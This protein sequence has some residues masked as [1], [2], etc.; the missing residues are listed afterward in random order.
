M[1]L[2]AVLLGL[3]GI[4]AAAESPD[5]TDAAFGALLA[6]PGAQPHEGGWIIPEQADPAPPN[7]E[8]LIARLRDLKKAGANFNAMRH[9][10]TLLAHAIR[11][12]KDRTAIWLLN[13]GADPKH[14]L[15]ANERSAYDLATE[16][17]RAA[18]KS[19]LEAK[20]G[21]KPSPPKAAGQAA[22]PAAAPKAA[23]TP[24]S[25]QQQTI[26]LM[27]RLL[28]PARRPTEAGRQE[29]QKFASTLS[30]E[31]YVATFRDG[32]RLQ[33]LVRLV[34]DT[35]GGLEGAL[36][37]LPVDLVRRQAQG[38]AELLAEVSYP[39]Y[40]SA[41]QPL[42]FTAASRNWP[43]LWKRIDQR[44]NYERYPDLAGR[45]PPAL[46]AGLFA[47]GYAKHDAEVTGCLLSAASADS[48]KAFW[49]DFLRHFSDAREQAT[50]LVLAN[51][52]FARERSPCYYA[53]GPAEVLK[54]LAFLR[55]QG[56]SR[57]VSG[58]R[59]SRLQESGDPSL[60]TALRA[61][62]APVPAAPRLRK[63]L[64]SC[65]LSLND[66]WLSA[67]IKAR[68]VGWG[69]PPVTVQAIGVPG[70]DRCG[71]ALSGD[72][73][74]ESSDTYDD[75]FNG[76][77][78]EGSTRCADLPDDGEIWI[79]KA[80]TISPVDSG[81]DTRGSGFIFRT[82]LDQKTGKRY[83]LDPG[84]RGALCSQSWELPNA[85]EWQAGP[86]GPALRPSGDDALVDGLLREQCREVAES[87]SLSCQGIGV[88]GEYE[89][90]AEPE[91]KDVLAMLREGEAVP[92]QRLVDVV[93]VERKKAY[94]AAIAARDRNEMRRLLSMGIAARWT[95]AEIR[96]LGPAELPLEE[97]RR[98]IALLFANADQ[99]DLAM[100]ED[101]FG[102]TESL[103][104]WLPMQDWGPVLRLIERS[105]DLWRGA[106]GALRDAAEKAGRGDLACGVDRAQG[107]LCGGGVRLD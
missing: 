34:R 8:A 53:S 35:D 18:V 97:K 42:T 95:A 11:A 63:A 92:I 81:S 31:D 80:G 57:P 38:I 88:L 101:R 29:W 89:S 79:E 10:G 20:F 4:A 45:V 48:L 77:G 78:R 69:I 7:E 12:G 51:Y 61:L 36:S 46:W 76:P 85:Y 73:Y 17:Q 50:S 28:G 66:A 82:V 49:P 94:Q 55:E 68:T 71:L 41:D 74:G 13:N 15:F 107:Y 6:M 90:G 59:M 75:F 104:G 16:S 24:K 56:V 19:V 40:S 54:K 39:L 86:R 37:P 9:R 25:R 60:A 103:L 96:A 5:S 44:L 83:L 2:A 27:D 32:E 1:L 43:A 62:S 64:L 106:A 30:R 14:V 22:T 3:A 47:S 65:T 67:L 98:R 91:A 99:L 105:P 21:F 87:Q 70:Q 100:S 93:G 102:L 84:K 33:E 26:E 23:E 58:L 72:G 52:R